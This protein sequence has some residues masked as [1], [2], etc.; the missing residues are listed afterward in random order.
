MRHR[1]WL[2]A[3]VACGLLLWER[4]CDAHLLNPFYTSKP[5]AIALDCW[6]FVLSG[7]ILPHLGVTLREAFLGLC[8]GSLAGVACGLLL[9]KVGWLA[10]MFEPVI[11]ALSGIPKLALAPL[12]ILWFGLGLESKIFLAGL[13]VFYLVFFSS[14]A[15]MRS[16]DKNMIAA[17]R[18]MGA[19]R[20]QL[21]R[22]VVL[23]SC[24]PWIFTGVRGGIGASLLGAIVGEYMGASAGLGW[25]IQY[26][27]TTY[28]VERVMSCILV[29]LLIGLSL[30]KLLS[31]CEQ[32]FLRWR[33]QAA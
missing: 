4:A 8:A 3:T 25:M 27:T 18:I 30:N 13:M 5:S 12:F 17:V 32:R 15:G 6:R 14:L 10:A 24:L 16:V 28:Q 33:A 11:T 21:V 7:E 20:W 23:P 26:A 2:A 22:A 31:L 1:I 9:G 29:L 19:S